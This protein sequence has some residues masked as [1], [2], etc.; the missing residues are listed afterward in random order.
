M[1]TEHWQWDGL[2]I[3]VEMPEKNRIERSVTLAAYLGSITTPEEIN[4]EP[5]TL[6]DMG[7]PVYSIKTL[8]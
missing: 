3:Q 2:Y 7:T 5:P 1:T 8:V 4:C 6:V